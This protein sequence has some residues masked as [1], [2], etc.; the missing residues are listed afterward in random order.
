MYNELSYNDIYNKEG[1]KQLTKM[2]G[3]K[4]CKKKGGGLVGVF[5]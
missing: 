1:V 3:C 4:L 5:L 2:K